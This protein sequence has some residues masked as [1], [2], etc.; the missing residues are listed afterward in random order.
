MPK[1]PII[2]YK[3]KLITA[4]INSYELVS[5]IDQNY[6][7]ENECVGSEHLVYSNIYPYYYIPE[8]Q[9]NMKTYVLLKVDISKRID[10]M[11]DRVKVYI[12]IFTHQDIM[13]V[14]SSNGTRVDL[15]SDIITKMFNNRDD[16]GFGEMVLTSNCEISINTTYR[17][18][19]LIFM[20]DEFNSSICDE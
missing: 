19:E 5:L 4:M 9:T 10:N 3:Q 1:A 13:K 7:N 15:I 2:V 20:V 17:G 16:F 14:Q 6:V 18:R 12:L 8:V 11:Y